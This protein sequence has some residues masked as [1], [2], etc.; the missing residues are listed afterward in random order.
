MSSTDLRFVRK[1]TSS[2][3]SCPLIAA[4]YVKVV[5]QVDNGLLIAS[6]K[7]FLEDEQEEDEQRETSQR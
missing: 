4:Y 3:E 1:D 2:R 7:S 5:H 6:K